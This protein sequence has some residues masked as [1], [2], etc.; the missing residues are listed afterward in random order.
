MYLFHTVNRQLNLMTI[1][2]LDK[3]IG[4]AMLSILRLYVSS[5]AYSYVDAELLH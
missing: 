1:P 2:N 3:K 4:T 5:Y